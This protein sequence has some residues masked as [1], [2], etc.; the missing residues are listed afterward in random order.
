LFFLQNNRIVGFKNRYS[1][2]MPQFSNIKESRRQTLLQSTCN[3]D[4]SHS[5]KHD[6]SPTMPTYL[7]RYL[8]GEHE[9]VWNE[10][11]ALGDQV[12]QE[13][14]YSDA[15]AVARETMQRSRRNIEKLYQRLQDLGYQF[16]CEKPH[17]TLNPLAGLRDQLAGDSLLNSAFGSMLS[18]IENMQSQLMQM[19]GQNRQPA[20]PPP[21][22]RAYAPPAEDIA[23]Q[24]DAYEKA[25]GPL[26]LSV[27]AWCEIVGS[28]NFIGDYPGLASYTRNDSGMFDLRG[29]LR[30]MMM[31]QP[32]MLDD[33]GDP[34]D[35]AV[36][37]YLEGINSPF[38]G[39]AM[40][41]IHKLMREEKDAAQ[42]EA[43]ANAQ[44]KPETWWATDPL[45]FDFELDEEE[46]RYEIEEQ[47][48]YGDNPPGTYGLMLHL[49]LTTKPIP[50]AALTTSSCLTLRR[51]HFYTAPT[52]ILSRTC[53]TASLGVVFPASPIIPNATRSCWP[54]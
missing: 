19:L 33:L 2:P 18:G 48:E 29:M 14:H 9:Q 7:E 30:G 21:P 42:A 38:G 44:R 36:Q 28:V 5:E 16:D 15:L 27:R 45:A 17:S 52:C 32:Q 25:I 11:I 43:A 13:P 24:L 26:P 31:Q 34:D 35:P 51:T 3:D 49:I 37:E 23:Q 10:L 4:L 53:G 41:G 50:A 22:P 47:T 54:R 40:M 1:T 20:E 12:R 39:A 6:W 8:N 46:A